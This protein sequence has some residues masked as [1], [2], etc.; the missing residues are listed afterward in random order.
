MTP[1]QK[2]RKLRKTLRTIANYPPPGSPRRTH[3]GYPQE[4]QYDKYAY[5]RMVDSFREAINKAIAE[6]K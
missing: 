2:L 1:E 3:D 5:Q 6:S 4:I